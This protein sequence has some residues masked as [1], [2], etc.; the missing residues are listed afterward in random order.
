MAK[1][2]VLTVLFES[3]E[4]TAA[5]SPM[6]A[7]MAEKIAAK[8]EGSRK[9]KIDPLESMTPPPLILLFNLVWQRAQ[10][11]PTMLPMVRAA[12]GL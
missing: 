4:A 12:P 8:R 5:D 2:T 7:S 3:T 1:L 11:N 6:P 10:T 9:W